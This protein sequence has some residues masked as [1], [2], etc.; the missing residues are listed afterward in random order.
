LFFVIKIIKKFYIKTNKIGKIQLELKNFCFK[1]FKIWGRVV[2][3][4]ICTYGLGIGLRSKGCVS[5]FM[6]ILIGLTLFFGLKQIEFIFDF[7]IDYRLFV[8]IFILSFFIY[9]N[10]SK[11]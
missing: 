11:K 5:S 10:P 7:F 8:I 1:L 3:S 2:C 9:S 4:Y 6:V